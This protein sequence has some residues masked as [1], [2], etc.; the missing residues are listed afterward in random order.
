MPAARTHIPAV[1]PADDRPDAD[2]LAAFLARR[3][4]AAFALLVSRHA[5][6][7]RAV[8]R[9]WLRN[10]ADVDDAAQATFLVLV[11][12]ADAIRD[13]RAVGGWLC[14]TAELV[15]RRLNRQ[16]R[17]GPGPLPPD[18]PGR[19]AG[20]P[21]DAAAVVHEEVARLP[22]R[23]RRPVQLCHLAGLTAA[24]AADRLGRPR[25]TVLAQLARGRELL[26]RRLAARGLAPTAAVAVAASAG[27]AGGAWAVARAAAAVLAGLPADGVSGRSVSLSQ[28]VADAMRW[29]RIRMA[30]AAAVVATGVLGFVAGQ[31][32]AAD[33][34]PANAADRPAAAGREPGA[35]PAADPDDGKPAAPAA[36][37]RE[38]VIRLPSGTFVK[39][40]DA[41]PYG[42]GRITWVY[43]DDTVRGTIEVSVMGVEVEVQTEAEISLSRNGT[44]YG[45][46]TSA[47]VT[48][49]KIGGELAELQQFAAFLPL[50]EPVLNE[51]LI[52]LPFSYQFRQAG[53]RL[54]L[55]NFRI[56]MAG[57]YGKLAAA[58]GLL[59]GEGGEAALIAVY[60]GA[61]GTALEGTYTAAEAGEKPAPKPR[62]VV[63]KPAEK[64]KS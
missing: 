32:A 29:N 60:F 9:G 45:L 20:P 39:D 18:V 33:P 6:A 58:A 55:T 8:C 30:A 57:P 17:R 13:R 22:E 21:D 10:P 1:R 40:V 42:A 3:D 61:V 56:L 38:A 37:R 59:G 34:R 49:V 50:V 19:T 11:R 63:R 62:P 7:V 5:P 2:L 15:A 54:T 47:K 48:H 23:Y 41:P 25:N 36:R 46:L 12:R 64:K 26:A 27:P 31:W 53:D 35:R 43:D 52:D 4:E 51:V 44:V 28:G 24:A 14:R 16:I